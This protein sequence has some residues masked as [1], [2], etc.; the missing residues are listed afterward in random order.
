MMKQLITVLFLG[1]FVMVMPGVF[2]SDQH[3]AQGIVKKI[4]SGDKKITISHGPIKSLGMDGMTMD[5]SVYD[6]SMLGEVKEGH[7]V[8]FL[9]EMDKSGNF[10]IMEIED[11][12]AAKAG[13]MAS[14]EDHSHQH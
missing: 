3:E 13:N 5:F 10:V 14:S 7:K 12:G 11:E 8:S 4:K 1:I 6:P 2:A 9:I